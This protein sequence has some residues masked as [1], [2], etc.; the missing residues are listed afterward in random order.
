[1]PLNAAGWSNQ[2]PVTVTWSCTDTGSGPVSPAVSQQVTGSGS[3]LS[4]TGI[5]QDRAG[6]TASATQTGIRIDTAAPLVTFRSPAS[7][8]QFTQGQNVVASY[9]CADPISGVASCTGTL[10]D[11]QVLQTATPGTFS[12]TVTATDVAGN[13]TQITHT[14]SVVGN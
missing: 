10:A 7:G 12:F 4:A 1:V 13:Q 2:S 11:G 6:N 3:G 8:A 14:Y 9:T 5:C